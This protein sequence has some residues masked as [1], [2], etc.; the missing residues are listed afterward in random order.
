MRAWRYVTRR[1]PD[2]TPFLSGDS[3][4][5]GLALALLLALRD[6]GERPPAAAFLFSPWTDLT[7]TGPSVDANRRR[8][9][10]LSRAHLEIWSRYYVAGRDPADPLI[11][12][13]HAD[14]RGLPP[15]LFTVGEHEVLLDDSRRCAAAARAAGVPVVEV[16]GPAM[17]HVFPI[18]LPW[19][20]ESRHAWQAITSFLDEHG[21]TAAA[22]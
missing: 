6:A 18:A 8:D 19:L 22:A 7:V 4:G 11:S 13:V 3:A 5:G 9:V 20:A 16:I 10:W 15:L 2:C 12:P 21:R 1:F 14:F 17:Q